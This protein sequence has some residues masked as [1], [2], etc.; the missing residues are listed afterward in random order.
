YLPYESAQTEEILASLEAEKHMGM[1][2]KWAKKKILEA[3]EK[4][5]VQ[6]IQSLYREYSKEEQQRFLWLES[7]KLLQAIYT[8][9]LTRS[10]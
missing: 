8:T 1:V 5:F 9:N 4:L 2:S 7:L 10:E 6:V 3:L